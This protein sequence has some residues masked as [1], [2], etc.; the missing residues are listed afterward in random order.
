[1]NTRSRWMNGSLLVGLAIGLLVAPLAY[2]KGKG[3]HSGGRASRAP[4]V[5]APRQPSRPPQMPRA[6]SP[7]AATPCEARRRLT[8][9][10][11][12]PIT[13]RPARVPRRFAPIMPRSPAAP[14]KP[15][16]I[17]R[18]LSSPTILRL[19]IGT[20]QALG[21]TTRSVANPAATT[22]TRTS[23]L[24]TTSPS[25]T[26]P[27]TTA[28]VTATGTAATPSISPNSY[29][30][31]LGAGARVYR[32]YGYG[33]GYRNVLMEA[34]MDTAGHRAT[35]APSSRGCGRCM[36]ACA[37]RSRLPG[38]SRPGDAC[39][40]D[41]HSPALAPLDGLQQHGFLISA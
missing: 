17:A 35:T 25:A 37:D 20:A 41:G 24:G 26:S 30:Y 27:S 14:R 7:G 8:T 38:P 19:A 23:V 32:A 22:P 21:S 28:G 9:R 6:T 16:P 39:D 34:G 11:L 36:R 33:R 3:G 10:K 31:G 4:R 29:T 1:M 40:L 18:T 5:S 15:A 12:A 2:A 13:R